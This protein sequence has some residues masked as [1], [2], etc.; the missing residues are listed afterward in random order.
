MDFSDRLKSLR[1]QAKLRQWGVFKA[2]GMSRTQYQRYESGMADPTLSQLNK[3]ADFFGVSL[4]YLVGRTDAPK[5]IIIPA[6]VEDS[7]SCNNLTRK[8]SNKK[9]RVIFQER[10]QT[11]RLAQTKSRREISDFFGLSVF[12]W[13]SY[14][15]G[16]SM[17]SADKIAEFADYFG[18]SIDWLMGR[19]DKPEVA[20]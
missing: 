20:R 19:T 9:G 15:L 13:Q 7:I 8:H 14:E 4:D 16:R 18:V 2:I 6:K 10:L 1:K 3:L 12:T 5:S 11:C 17:P